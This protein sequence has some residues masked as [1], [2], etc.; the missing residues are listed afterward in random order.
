MSVGRGNVKVVVGNEG[1]ALVCVV[2]VGIG[3]IVVVGTG[4]AANKYQYYINL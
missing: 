1:N 3:R 2:M 4:K